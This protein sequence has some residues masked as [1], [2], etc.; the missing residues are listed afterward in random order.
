MAAQIGSAAWMVVMMEETSFRDGDV[1]TTSIV[2]PG[3][4]GSDGED[5]FAVGVAHP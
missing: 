3:S 4:G 2:A 1:V 5:W